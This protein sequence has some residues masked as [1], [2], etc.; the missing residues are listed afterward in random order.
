MGRR[1]R[2]ELLGEE[3]RARLAKGE[4]TEGLRQKISERVM[5]V[6]PSGLFEGAGAGID[7]RALDVRFPFLPNGSKDEEWLAMVLVWNGDVGKWQPGTFQLI[8]RSVATQP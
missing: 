7:E 6:R 1:E 2:A 3:I 8:Q 4:Q 5:E